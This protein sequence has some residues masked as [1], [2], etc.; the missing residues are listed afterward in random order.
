[1]TAVDSEQGTAVARA[2]GDDVVLGDDWIS[3]GDVVDG[4]LKAGRR[5]RGFLS[6]NS[7]ALARKIVTFNLVALAILVAGILFLN[8]SRDSLISQRADA[9]ATVSRLVAD[10][11]EA[12]LD[13]QHASLT[14]DAETLIS[15]LAL[16]GS[17][18]VFVFSAEGEMLA[19]VAMGDAA[20][21]NAGSSDEFLIT[22]T[23]DKLRNWLLEI[24][25]TT[26]INDNMGVPQDVLART[27]GQTALNGGIQ[28]VTSK[29]LGGG[30]LFAVASPIMRNDII[31]GTVAI[32]TVDAAMDRMLQSEREQV[33]KLAL[34][35]ILVSIGLS[36][37]LASLIANP[38][39]DLADAVEVGNDRSRKGG[40]AHNR[41]RIP[42][43]TA[44]PDE[45][46]RL[47]GALR[48]MVGALY[49]RIESN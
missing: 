33:L 1:M 37:I 49:E 17:N 16:R 11:V 13:T 32:T 44:R 21:Q 42:D 47:S 8:P 39:S 36:L 4:Q 43:L 24:A 35:A 45:I 25:G 18:Q 28:V 26:A 27:V 23:L 38:L 19:Q 9:L 46:G 48:G 30:T 15:D 34:V 40:V 41:I 10:T 2:R 31:L 12:R 22:D 29:S 6:L 5:R 14:G 3:P 7:S 20:M